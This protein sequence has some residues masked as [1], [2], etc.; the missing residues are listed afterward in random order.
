LSCLSK[1]LAA[2]AAWLLVAASS[3]AG[4]TCANPFFAAYTDLVYSKDGSALILHSTA[5]IYVFRPGLDLGVVKATGRNCSQSK[6]YSLDCMQASPDAKRLS[7]LGDAVVLPVTEQVTFTLLDVRRSPGGGY[8]ETEVATQVYSAQMAQDGSQVVYTRPSDQPQAIDLWHVGLDGTATQ[9]VYALPLGDG[10]VE[11]VISWIVVTPYGIAYPRLDADG[12][13][14]DPWFR[15]WDRQGFQ[16]GTLPKECAGTAFPYCVHANADGTAVVWQEKN[17]SVFHAYRPQADV[18]LPLGEGYA[19]SFSS[20]G[21]FLLRMDSPE[22]A[23][24]QNLQSAVVER[25][26]GEVSQATLSTDGETLAWLSIDSKVRKTFEL[27]V[28]LS[29]REGQDRSLGIFD[30]PPARP[31]LGG[32]IGEAPVGIALTGDARYVIIETPPDEPGPGAALTSVN[33]DTGE[34]RLLGSLTCEGCCTVATAGALVA[35]FPTMKNGQLTDAAPVDL[36]DPG[37]G[38]KTRVAE[39]VILLSPLADGSG[40]TVLDYPGDIPDGLI[41]TKDGQ[42]TDLG[43]S[44]RVAASPKLRQVARITELGALSIEAIP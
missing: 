11:E 42:R 22:I 29:R 23:D 36:Y 41:V 34:I 4:C 32:G 9:I 20:G 5:G 38:T 35:C 37:T 27:H 28:G 39:K 16:I 33:T 18:D 1:S 7:V 40:V 10:K 30:Q 25:A 24:I 26:I 6:T 3:L 44:L 17:G 14:I 21:S 8:D 2:E 31:L 12:S 13:S 19:F 15:P 43:G